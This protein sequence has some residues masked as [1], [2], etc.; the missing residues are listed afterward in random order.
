MF[1]GWKKVAVFSSLLMGLA[2][3]G[4]WYVLRDESPP[5]DAHLR[6]YR[7]SVKE[8][9]NGFRLVDLKEQDVW[10]DGEEPVLE[11]HAA[12]LDRARA[13]ELVEKNAPLI[14]RIDRCLELPEFQVDITSFRG[15]Y[16]YLSAW[17]RL[18]QVIAIRARLHLE[19]RRPVD[20]F[21]DALRILR[22][23]W[24]VQRSQGTSLVYLVGTGLESNG[25]ELLLYIAV[26]GSIPAERM[27]S[28][29]SLLGDSLSASSWLQDAL[30]AEYAVLSKAFDDLGDGEL[31]DVA[32]GCGSGMYSWL[33]RR[34]FFKP[35]RTKRHL[36]EEFDLLVASANV[37]RRERA[38]LDYKKYDVEKTWS[39]LLRGGTGD[40][41]LAT[42]LVACESVF[43]RMDA[44]RFQR[45]AMRA[46][47]ALRLARAETGVLPES[48][49]ELVPRY[50][51]AVPLDADGKK[52]RYSASKQIIYSIGSDGEDAG[53]SALEDP[54]DAYRDDQEPTFRFSIE[55]WDLEALE[56]KTEDSAKR[57]KKGPKPRTR[58]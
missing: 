21:E 45:D 28:S 55:A 54:R 57:A 24:R 39:R 16:H 22:L 6:S 37:P 19:S 30:R 1:S 14:E 36:S 43:A 44:T 25:L 56:K 33:F 51:S 50:L 8:E 32:L 9:E 23:A 40:L 53:G 12:K 48:L 18:A 46:V 4:A 31:P 34:P 10:S 38:P 3:A 13:A 52:L 35:N 49:D 20:A 17:T 26:Q 7:R 47:L 27:R 41:L 5:A 58:P 29:I 2:I 42:I 11:W 15:P